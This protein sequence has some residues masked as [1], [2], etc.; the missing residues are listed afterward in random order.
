MDPNV[1]FESLS[2]DHFFIGKIT[3]ND[4]DPSL[5]TNY[6]SPNDINNNNINNNFESFQ[7][8]YH[9]TNYRFSIVFLR[10]MGAF[11]RSK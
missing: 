2:Y 11:L 1:N 6:H 3:D 4:H 7:D 10:N 9:N 5:N 8:L